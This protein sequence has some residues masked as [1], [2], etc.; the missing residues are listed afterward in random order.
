MAMDTNKTTTQ[1]RWP[2][3]AVEESGVSNEVEIWITH[4]A[5]V[6]DVG[7]P[8][9]TTEHHWDAEIKVG[10]VKLVVAKSAGMGEFDDA[11]NAFR[12]AIVDARNTLATM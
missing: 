3:V 10:R 7:E 1:K 5:T 9:E 2:L 12:Q 4:T 8:T 11:L 6:R